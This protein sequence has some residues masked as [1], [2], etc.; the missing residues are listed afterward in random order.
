MEMFVC[1]SSFAFL[2]LERLNVDK[3]L[4]HTVFERSYQMKFL[5]YTPLYAN[6]I[7]S[8]IPWSKFLSMKYF[9][10]ITFYQMF[11]Y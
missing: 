4:H 6:R 3:A 2:F 7:K 8:A 1:K 11:A 5:K 10:W 9:A